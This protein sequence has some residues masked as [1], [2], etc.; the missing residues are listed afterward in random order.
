MVDVAVA[1]VVSIY[2]CAIACVMWVEA[3][4]ILHMLDIFKHCLQNG[5]QRQWRGCIGQP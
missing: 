3:H 2:G 5:W 4:V 1:I